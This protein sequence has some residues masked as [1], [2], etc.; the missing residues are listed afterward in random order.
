MKSSYCL[1]FNNA[2]MEV[3]AELPEQTYKFTSIDMKICALTEKG[4]VIDNNLVKDTG[5]ETIG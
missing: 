1:M 4:L 2:S 5:F 3:E